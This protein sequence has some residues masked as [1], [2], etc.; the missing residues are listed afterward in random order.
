MGDFWSWIISEKG[1]LAVAGALGGMV[2]WLSLREDWKSGTTS[3]VVGA[4][5]AVYLGPLAI[6]VIEPIV[7]KIVIDPASRAGLSGFIIGV[8]GIA[9]AGFIIDIWKARRRQASINAEDKQP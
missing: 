3:L 2:R 6:P 9:V 5:C 8:G 4:I 7:G 1:Q